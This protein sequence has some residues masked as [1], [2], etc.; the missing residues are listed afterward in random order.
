MRLNRVLTDCVPSQAAKL[1]F[2]KNKHITAFYK[3]RTVVHINCLPL[4]ISAVAAPNAN[5]G[6]LL[7]MQQVRRTPRV[8][9]VA[10]LQF[11][12]AHTCQDLRT[13]LEPLRQVVEKSSE[14]NS[15]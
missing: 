14:N 6:L 11:V 1:Q 3:D 10:T 12:R 2:G 7:S 15:F 5:I 9:R 4:V 8:L 13:A